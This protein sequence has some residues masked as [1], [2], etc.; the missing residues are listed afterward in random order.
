M[1]KDTLNRVIIVLGCL[2]P[3]TGAQ[4]ANTADVTVTAK[5]HPVFSIANISNDIDLFDN[6][7]REIKLRATTNIAS[8]K[9]K[10]TLGG[11]CTVT[12]TS[13]NKLKVKFAVKKDNKEIKKPFFGEKFFAEDDVTPEG[14]E[15]IL[16]VE[17]VGKKYAAADDYEGELT[18]TIASAS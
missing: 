1:Y 17:P 3:F 13:N 15:I 8:G 10:I 14:K 9:V 12:S 5:V 16:K 6:A 4:A 2:S 18:F 7:K 11:D